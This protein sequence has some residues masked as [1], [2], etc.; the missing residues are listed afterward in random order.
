MQP[1]ITVII[2][3]YNMETTVEKSIAPC[4]GRRIRISS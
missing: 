1:R 4:S 3:A 2:P